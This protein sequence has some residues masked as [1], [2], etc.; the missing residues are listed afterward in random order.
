MVVLLAGCDQG[1]R[2]ERKFQQ[3][4]CVNNL[5]QIGLS[6]RIWAGDHNDQYPFNT[7][8]N[9]GGSMELC[10][11]GEDGFD[12]NAYLHFQ[13]MSNE[14]STP[15]ILICPQDT[16]K[17]IAADFGSLQ[18]SNVTYLLRSGTNLIEGK[19]HE[20]LVVCP[21]DGNVLYCDGTVVKKLK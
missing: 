19:P 21:I 16:T 20:I 17:K 18:S 10:A 3:I 1:N 7:S 4:T 12:S 13:V 2:D 15:L 8:T 6:L 9:T 14:L 5:K 11:V